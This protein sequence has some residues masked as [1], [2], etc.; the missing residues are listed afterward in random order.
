MPVAVLVVLGGWTL[1]SSGLFAWTWWVLPLCWGIAYLLAQRSRRES[2]PLQR[3]I[4]WTSRD[5]EAS[6]LIELHSRQIADLNTEQ[7]TDPRFYLDSA[8]ELA[9]KIAR[10]YEPRAV[11]PIGSLRVPEVLAAAHLAIEDLE[12]WVR[13]TVPASHLLTIRQWKRL[14]KAPD[15]I[16]KAQN[17]AWA[18]S[19]VMNPVN[20][21][22]FLVSKFTTD[23]L[24]NFVQ[25]NLLAAFYAAFIRQVG[26]YLI[27]MN[28][29]RLRSGSERYRELVADLRQASKPAKQRAEVSDAAEIT[30][31]VMGQVKAGK[32]SVIN[33]LL[34]NRQ[35]QTDVLPATN[36]VTRYQWQPPDHSLTV[37][38]LDTPG[39]ADADLTARQLEELFTAFQQTDAMLLVLDATRPARDPDLKL[40]DAMAARFEKERHLRPPPVIGVLTHIDGLS[41]LMEWSP[42][43]DWQHPQR[44]KECSIHDAVAYNR[45]LFGDRLQV[46]VPVC[47]DSERLEPYG[48]QE[49]L[50]PALCECL[51]EGHARALVRS[52]HLEASNQ[53]ISELVSQFRNAG[54]T[55][56]QLLV[57]PSVRSPGRSSRTM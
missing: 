3:G 16:S 5:D 22:R 8:I 54:R 42:P 31:A 33:L 48:L 13:E 20:I 44:P 34:G 46:V 53:R 29:G 21:F 14:A 19:T 26:F 27:E 57:K 7:L 45:T 11:D 38:L 17:V 49:W 47:S 43:Y 4:H 56:I 1:W 39:Y 2:I 6:H 32:S 40:L 51:D 52:L 9:V 36:E 24:A 30:L 55:I 10:H 12:D 37:G 23:P 18:I 28:S 25:T 41:P 35:A 50:L 15:W